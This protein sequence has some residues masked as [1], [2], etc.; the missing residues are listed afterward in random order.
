[1]V[2]NLPLNAR[3]VDSIPGSGRSP[4]VGNGKPLQYSCLGNHSWTEK[5]GG[6][7]SMESQKSQTQLSNQTATIRMNHYIAES[8]HN[9]SLSQIFYSGQ[10]YF[11]F[12]L[13]Y[14]L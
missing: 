13:S 2:K 11:K 6:L 8:T 12:P 14:F 7:Q 10:R 3:E 9:Y 5:P 4:G 1:M